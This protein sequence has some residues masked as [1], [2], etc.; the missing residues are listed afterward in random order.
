MAID[1]EENIS[2]SKEEH[3]FTQN[4]LSLERLVSLKT[5]TNNF[6]ERREKDID[7]QGVDEKGFND[8]FQSHEEEKEITHAY[9]DDNEDMVEE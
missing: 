7:Q 2:L 1:I 9:I 8:G 4:T 6:Q 3:L 5:F